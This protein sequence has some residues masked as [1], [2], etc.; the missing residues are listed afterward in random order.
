MMLPILDPVAGGSPGERSEA[1]DLV[2]AELWISFVSLLRSHLGALQTTGKLV[3]ATF[4]ALSPQEIEIVDLA[5]TLHITLQ[6]SSGDGE[7]S[8]R[9]MGEMIAAG[10]WLLRSDATATIDHGRPVDMELAVEAFAE[11]LWTRAPFT[12]PLPSDEE[13]AE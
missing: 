4:V 12:T 11:K 8:L 7:W 5:R 2:L 6:A 10:N 13:T 3:Q 1:D 9:R